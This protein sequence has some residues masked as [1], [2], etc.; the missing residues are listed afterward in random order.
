MK[1]DFMSVGRCSLPLGNIYILTGIPE[2]LR[3]EVTWEA[4]NKS[5]RAISVK[6]QEILSFSI[7][8]KQKIRCKQENLML[9]AHLADIF[10]I[11]PLN[12]TIMR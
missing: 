11:H 1:L 4:K 10:D 6:K 12:S 2:F 9:K 8:M 7:M 5:K 3:A